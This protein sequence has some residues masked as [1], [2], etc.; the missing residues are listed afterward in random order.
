[1][2]E[3]EIKDYRKIL[4]KEF[5]DK[6]LEIETSLSYIS[7]G[8]LGFFITINE[9]FLK[10]QAANYKVILIL[11][12]SFIFISFILILFRKSR[13]S[14]HDLQLMKF[15]D[16]MKPDTVSEDKQLLNLW[17]ISHKELSLGRTLIYFSLAIG[18]G[19]QVLFLL[20]NI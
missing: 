17:N 10:I 18:I 14:H 3:T 15:I 4:E 19:L 2:N 9:K 5:I 7:I 11:S 8:T 13:T 12:L 16:K 6:D 1:M 20:L